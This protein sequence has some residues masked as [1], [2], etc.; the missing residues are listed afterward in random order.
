[1]F[2]S[3]LAPSGWQDKRV[4][5]WPTRDYRGVTTTEVKRS[6]FHC[7]LA[8]T[9]GEEQARAVIAQARRQF[10]GARHHCTAY[11]YGGVGE[12]PTQRSSDD[13]EP[14]GTAGAPMLEV[15]R[16]AGLSNI[17]A[18]VSRIFGGTLL[19]TGGLA[20]AYAGAVTDGLAAMPRVRPRVRHLV[21][22]GVDHADAGRVLGALRDQGVAIAATEYGDTVRVVVQA[23]DETSVAA[24]LAHITHGAARPEAAGQAVVE[25]PL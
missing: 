5:Q 22:F 17:T 9:D 23:E 20:R 7:T 4:L 18:V 1:M 10:P 19:G 12:N 8:R 13:G 2:G 3:S 14:S 6:L 21:A 11:L 24:L 16:G 25:V 15:L